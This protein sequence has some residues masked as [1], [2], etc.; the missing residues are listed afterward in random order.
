MSWT[1]RNAANRH[2]E[3]PRRDRILYFFLRPEIG[4]F[5]PHF[6]SISLLNYT[7]DPLEKIQK[8]QWRDF[9]KIADLCRL[10]WSDAS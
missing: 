8:L 10:S 2:L 6:G 4:Q 9:P 3:M 1:K 7:E 5:S